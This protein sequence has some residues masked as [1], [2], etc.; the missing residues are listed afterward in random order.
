MVVKQN[1]GL[2]SYKELNA[3]EGTTIYREAL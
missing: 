2:A 1:K 3:R